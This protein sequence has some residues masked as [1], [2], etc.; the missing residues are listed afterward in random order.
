MNV[1][2]TAIAEVSDDL[3]IQRE[4][5]RANLA[6]A[7]IWAIVGMAFILVWFVY[8]KG[9]GDDAKLL[10]TGVLTPLIGIGGTVLGFY[11]GSQDTK[12]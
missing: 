4:S 6:K 3:A 7:I 11:F 1:F 10:I 2:P 8:K 5:T 12:K 9:G